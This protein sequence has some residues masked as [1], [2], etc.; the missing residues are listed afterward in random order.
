MDVLRTSLPR[1]HQKTTSTSKAQ[2]LGSLTFCQEAVL[3]IL[4]LDPNNPLYFDLAPN[5]GGHPESRRQG[6]YGLFL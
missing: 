2:N 1:K 3:V 6:V 4:F 5:L